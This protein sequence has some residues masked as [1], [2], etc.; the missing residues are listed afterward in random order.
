M[1]KPFAE[2]S[3]EV[4]KHIDPSI[5]CRVYRNLHKNCLSV[6]QNG[7]VKCHAENV[8]LQNGEFIVREKGR[9]RVRNEKRKNV[10]AFIEG[11]VVEAITTKPL[12]WFV[13]DECYYNPYKCDT[14]QHKETSTPIK[15]AEYIDLNCNKVEGANVIAFNISDIPSEILV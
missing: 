15:A 7:I 3:T 4:L 2:T 1:L 14:W 6:Q 9:E 11:F 13:W 8:V 12:L 5:K 10:H